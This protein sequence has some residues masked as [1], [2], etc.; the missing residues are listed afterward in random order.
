MNFPSDIGRMVIEKFVTTPATSSI[1]GYPRNYKENEALLASGG[2]DGANDRRQAQRRGTFSS[3]G[4]RGGGRGGRGGLRI[5]SQNWRSHH[6]PNQRYDSSEED[7]TPLAARPPRMPKVQVDGHAPNLSTAGGGNAVTYQPGMLMTVAVNDRGRL[8]L[9]PAPQSSASS[10]AS[11]VGSRSNHGSRSSNAMAMPGVSSHAGG[12]HGARSLN[13]LHQHASSMSAVRPPSAANASLLHPAVSMGNIGSQYGMN[14][15]ISSFDSGYG[16]TLQPGDETP[17]HRP[18]PHAA[19]GALSVEPKL[20]TMENVEDVDLLL[21]KF[22]TIVA[23]QYALQH[24]LK[25]PTQ[26]DMAI[27]LLNAK[28]ARAMAEKNEVG[29]KLGLLGVKQI[30]SYLPVRRDSVIV[31][32]QQQLAITSGNGDISPGRVQ[33]TSMITPSG[34][35]DNTPQAKENTVFDKAPGGSGRAKSHTYNQSWDLQMKKS[36]TD[37]IKS[38]KKSPVPASSGQPKSPFFPQTNDSADGRVS[39]SFP[40][41]SRSGPGSTPTDAMKNFSF[42]PGRTPTDTSKSFS[43]GPP[44]E[45]SFNQSG[46]SGKQNFSFYGSGGGANLN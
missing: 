41:P 26:S 4:E 9:V 15:Q 36:I 21:A 30:A 32:N 1:L 27:R 13:S 24:Q 37:L 38:P 35:N 17:T 14:N 33:G 44:A 28:S 6:D 42:G 3:R 12:L 18:P 34:G 25:L 39:A 43:F 8:V 20:M 31:A 16:T 2:L 40:T 22:H 19:R 7:H 10:T 23:E 29:S 46:G 5:N 11:S 45:Q